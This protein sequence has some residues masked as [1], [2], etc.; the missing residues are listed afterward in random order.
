MFFKYRKKA[1][2]YKLEFSEDMAWCLSG[3]DC[4]EKN[5]IHWLKKR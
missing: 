4:Y 3:D 5:V 2:G 1:D